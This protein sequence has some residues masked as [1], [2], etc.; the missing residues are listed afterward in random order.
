MK[1]IFEMTDPSQIEAVLQAESYGTLALSHDDKS[2][3]LPINFVYH[4]EVFYFHG[5]K[6]GRK[7]RIL[8][9]NPA[10]S[11]SVIQ[12]HALI[13]SFFSS[14]EQLAC[15]ATHFF[16]SV[17]AEGKVS[18]VE[19]YDEKVAALTALMQK[20]Q[21][22][23]GYKPLHEAVY[24]KMIDATCVWKLVPHQIH[25][26]WKFGQH[27]PEERFEKIVKHL[28][29]RGEKVDKKSVAEMQALRSQ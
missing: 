25:G 7:I 2:Y 29:A 14:D 20:L 9:A 28:Q 12:A 1:Q 22:E 13:P 19:D 27:L 8:Q 15:P 5:A 26:K 3:S 10:A 23:G 21:P 16:K 24:R 18:F 4:K 17:I 6:S 11:F